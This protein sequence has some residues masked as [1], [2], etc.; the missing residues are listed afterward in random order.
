[1]AAKQIDFDKI[2]TNNYNEKYKIIKDLGT[3][4]HTPSYHAHMVRIKFIDSGYEADVELK[5]AEKGSTKDRTDIDVNFNTIYHSLSGDYKIIEYKFLVAD[6]LL[7]VVF[8]VGL[9]DFY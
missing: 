1:M 6:S 9:F 5:S 4:Y 3:I 7:I 8:V 2:Y